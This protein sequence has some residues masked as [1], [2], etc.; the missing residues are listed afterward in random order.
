MSRNHAAPSTA[1]RCTAT[2]NEVFLKGAT[3]ENGVISSRKICVVFTAS[4]APWLQLYSLALLALHKTA[5]SRTI[6][7]TL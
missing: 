3:L 4:A 7:C 1:W 2:G 6:S 5:Q